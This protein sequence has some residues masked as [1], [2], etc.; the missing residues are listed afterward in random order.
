MKI[1]NRNLSRNYIIVV[2]LYSPHILT[3]FKEGKCHVIL[4]ASFFMVHSHSTE[5]LKWSIIHCQDLH[6]TLGIIKTDLEV[7]VHVTLKYV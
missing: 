6:E 7:T 5:N 2:T 3:H 1:M 4:K